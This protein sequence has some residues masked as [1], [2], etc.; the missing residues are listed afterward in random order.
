MRSRFEI[1]NTLSIIHTVI[2]EQKQH[3]RP[4]DCDVIQVDNVKMGTYPRL[5]NQQVRVDNV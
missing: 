3:A 4:S 2:P 5:M 1:T